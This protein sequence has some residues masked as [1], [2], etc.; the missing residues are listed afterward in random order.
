MRSSL[1][2]ITLAVGAAAQT[3]L[4]TCPTPE[5]PPASVHKSTVAARFRSMAV[6]VSRRSIQPASPSTP[7]APTS[8]PTAETTTEPPTAEP[9]ADP[10]SEPTAEPTTT[11]GPTTSTTTTTLPSETSA[12]PT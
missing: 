12:A 5:I 3:P 11:S 7:A 4:E 10:T 8:E 9:T 6:W 1:V 2:L